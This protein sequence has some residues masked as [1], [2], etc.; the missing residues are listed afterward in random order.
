MPF[1]VERFFELFAQYNLAIWPMQIVAMIAGLL[2]LWLL[3]SSTRLAAAVI[4]G[5][6]GAMWL[7]NGI[8]YHWL[9]FAQINPIARVFAAIFVLQ[10][11]LLVFA[12]L[13]RSGLRFRIG[14]QPAS[15]IGLACVLFAFF[16]YPVIGWLAGHR[17]PAMPMFGL[18]PCPTT[19]F[20]IGVLLLGQWREVRWLLAIPGIWA[21]IG[22]SASFLLGVPQDYALFAALAGVLVLA[23][24][25][26]RGWQSLGA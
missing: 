20:T 18:A 16:I 22:G 14:K 7:V 8:G 2:V 25:K 10:A 13:T 12:A 9:F 3:W 5:L 17:Y 24:G 15:I 26:W 23:F 11:L 6:L 21:A 1:T 4:L 19:I